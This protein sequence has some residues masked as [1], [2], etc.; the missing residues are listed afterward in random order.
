MSDKNLKKRLLEF[1]LSDEDEDEA[2]EN[3]K[4]HKKIDDVEQIPEPPEITEEPKISKS[5]LIEKINK[6]F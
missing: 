2:D 3:P 1:L 4:E 6:F 5:T